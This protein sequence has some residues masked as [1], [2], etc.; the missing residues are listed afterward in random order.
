M[1]KVVKAIVGVA[2]AVVGVFTGNPLLIAQGAAMT[3]GAVLQKSNAGNQATN[4]RLSKTLEPEDFRKIVFGRTACGTDLRYWETWGS[5]YTKFDE[6]LAAATHTIQS[7]QETYIEEELVSFSGGAAVGTYSGA[8]S[9]VQNT[10][11]GHLSAGAG[12][13]WSANTKM[14][15]VPHWVFKWEY[16]E[17]KLPQGI[18]S[19][20]TRVVEGALVYD[21]RKDSTRGGSGTHRADDQTTWQYAPTDSNGVPIGRNNALQLLWYL[22]GWRINGK[23]VA[24]RGV[25]LLDID[26]ASFIT[27]ANDCEALQ[28]YTD[29]ILSTGD[30]HSTNESILSADGLIGELIDAGGYWSYRITKNDLGD[31]A[32]ALDDNDVV[33]GGEVQWVPFKPM[34]DK[35]NEVAGTF[36]DP[37]P[38]SLYQS[39][40]YRTVSDATYYALDGYK[41]RK[42]QNFQS[43]Q[44]SDLAQKLARI[45]LNRAR[46]AGEFTAT[47][48]LRA[49][50]A[51]VWDIVWL[52]LERY[53]FANKPFRVIRQSISAQGVEMVLREEDSSIYTG[54]TVTPQAP[55]SAGVKYD[56]RMEVPVTGL[57]VAQDTMAGAGGVAYDAAFVS[58]TTPPGN[59][60]RT[61]AQYKLTSSS[62]WTSAF[63]SQ[64]DINVCEV[65]PLLPGSSYQMRVRHVSIHEV[66]GPWA[67]ISLTTGVNGRLT[68]AQVTYA[69]GTSI[70]V[71]R[72]SDPGATAGSNLLQN[73][74][75]NAGSMAFWGSGSS[76]TVQA[77]IA[78]DPA[79]YYLRGVGAN[80]YIYAN[81]AG[82]I[83]VRGGAK[84][85][86]GALIR[87]SSTSMDCYIEAVAYNAAGAVVG[88]PTVWAVPPAANSWFYLGGTAL[89]PASAV[90]VQV[91]V[92]GFWST[93]SGT[94]E[95][96]NPYAGHSE[97]GADITGGN[98]AA[99]IIG[100][101]PGATASASA[102]MNA[103]TAMSAGNLVN[104]SN[105]RGGLSQWGLYYVGGGDSGFG[106]S[107][108]A[109]LS[110]T[111][112]G[113]LKVD[114][115]NAMIW[116]I[117][118]VGPKDNGSLRSGRHVYR[119]A[120][121]M[122]F[123]WRAKG[124]VGG[125][126]DWVGPYFRL[127]NQDCTVEVGGN[128][129]DVGTFSGYSS[130]VNASNA[131]GAGYFDVPNIAGLYWVEVE[132]Y[133][134]KND[135]TYGAGSFEL[136]YFQLTIIPQ[137]QVVPPPLAEGA[138][139]EYL[140]DVTATQ[141]VTIEATTS[142]TINA[143]Y[144]GTIATDVLPVTVTQPKVVKGGVTITT[145]NAT[146]YTIQ[147]TQGGCVG[148]VTVDNT[149]GSTTKGVVTIGTGF[150][151]SGSYELLVTVSG[152]AYPAVK[153]MVTKEVGVPPSG[154]SG[155]TSAYG[156]VVSV[157]NSTSFMSMIQLN[158]VAV[159]SG[160]TAN[161]YAD[162][163]YELSATA[164][165]ASR[166]LSAKWQYSPAGA[167]TWTDIAAAVTGTVAFYS[168]SSGSEDFGEVVCNQSKSGLTAGNYDFR[169]VG[170]I[171]SIANGARLDCSGPVSINVA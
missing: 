118:S 25:D 139:G 103:Y 31:V 131:E 110:I 113:R 165:N 10:T 146:T 17:K 114:Q 121:G 69:D 122:R 133:G 37:S 152:I 159:A 140:A 104:N 89:L 166:T 77:G 145:D 30:N 115:P 48:N 45:L 151:A 8:L 82:K 97:P 39:R 148:N 35:Y 123:A 9:V 4:G 87:S 3:L 156:Y 143:D 136:E 73:S 24:G 138:P 52:S 102:V 20:Y 129:G 1:S 33:E 84:L 171:S 60:R 109:T 61:E 160:K 50:K 141:Q 92:Q 56:P 19:R 49:L 91:F 153:V 98:T 26:F 85:F 112:T 100:Q 128:W 40:T 81:S 2:V 36:I 108:M 43:V 6:V 55:P 132:I 27:A 38:T 162:V 54:G 18:P 44:S 163:S 149:T 64:A 93:G 53:G 80:N 161:C 71:L 111:S 144:T 126:C 12:L 119:V 22:I 90:S 150:N 65:G 164:Y 142:K 58:W 5:K 157:V 68:S 116:A 99:A 67:T 155:G 15:G 57:A 23:L 70:E 124:V 41:K 59:V 95:F 11:G 62:T 96:A 14:T 134:V 28:Y 130:A 29:C 158:G 107:G 105:F 125:V 135:T 167:N 169:L 74:A 78:G 88:Y 117:G 76:F 47:F 154:G 168:Q 75:F 120:P 170:A 21:P 127:F 32:V 79:P 147:N 46:Y 66:P 16:S 7:F 42:M 72:P 137:T 86:M 94:F 83:P 13:Y 63:T 101:G 34:S 106:P 51:R